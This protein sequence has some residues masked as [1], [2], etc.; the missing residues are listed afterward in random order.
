MN[1]EPVIATGE[2]LSA[3]AEDLLIAVLTMA[4]CYAESGNRRAA[5]LTAMYLRA[6]AD[7]VGPGLSERVRETCE[8]MAMRWSRRASRQQVD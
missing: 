8:G 3:Q 5:M 7:H 1:A 6:L 4:G 2:G